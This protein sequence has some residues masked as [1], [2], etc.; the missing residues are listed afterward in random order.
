MQWRSHVE[1]RKALAFPKFFE[2]S[3][4]ALINW[5]IIY[6]LF[7]KKKIYYVF[8][9]QLKLICLLRILRFIKKNPKKDFF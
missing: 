2:I 5:K 7:E 3:F 1:T 9:T 4:I 6:K 8:I